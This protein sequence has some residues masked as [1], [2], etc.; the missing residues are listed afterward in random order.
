MIISKMKKIF[1]LAV[2]M[3]VIASSLFFASCGEDEDEE[4]T[5]K[6]EQN[7]ND[8]N[9]GNGDDVPSDDPAVTTAAQGGS[10][11]PSDDTTAAVAEQSIDLTK[12][13]LVRPE[14]C[15]ATLLST[16]A[17][18]RTE[19]TAL[20]GVEVK[21]S[22]DWVKKGESPDNDNFEILLGATN[23]AQSIAA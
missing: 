5:P 8:N 23:R 12:Y 13:I 11:L 7:N 16:A 21:I 18:L 9:N 17:A 2:A 4:E 19:L 1:N 14:T 15:E 20:C 10:E 3:S 22:D 6:Q